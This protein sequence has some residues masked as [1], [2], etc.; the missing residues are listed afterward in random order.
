MFLEAVTV[1]VGYADFLAYAILYNKPLLDY[2]IIV[3]T[4]DDKDT[5]ALADQS[6][7]HCIQ[8][9]VFYE[10]DS[11]FNKARG[12]NEGLKYL[13]KTDWLL[14][15]DGDLVLPPKTRSI[16]E[17]IPLDKSNIYGIDRM[18]CK[19][20]Y[21]WC[22]YIEKPT[23]QYTPDIFINPG[24]FEIGT[25]VAKLE[26]GGFL[27][28]G[29]WQLW[30]SSMGR[31]VYPDAHDSAGR[32]DMLHALRWHRLNRQLLPEIIGIH[33]ESESCKMGTNWNGRKTKPF[34]IDT[35][36]NKY[37]EILNIW[38]MSLEELYGNRKGNDSLAQGDSGQRG[39]SEGLHSGTGAYN[40]S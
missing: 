13:K 20:F 35:E 10:K 16:L 32:T 23:V 27:P 8:T 3:T 19:S 24:P 2:W 28:I 18:L 30:H 12:I 17:K 31:N 33:L 29:Y 11:V 21:D 38:D 9:K 14:H 36:I 34:S 15:L 1:C 25:R 40:S 37:K 26:T 7:L 4:P 39:S 22:K 5:I 6:G